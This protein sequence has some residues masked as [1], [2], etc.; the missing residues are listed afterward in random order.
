MPT[1]ADYPD[2]RAYNEA[3]A[4]EFRANGAVT[5]DFAGRNL[6]LLTTTGAKS[7]RAHVTPLGYTLIGERILI[8]AGAGGQANNPDWYHNLV[9]DPEVTVELPGDTFKARAVVTEGEERQRLGEERIKTNANFRR[10][11]ERTSRQ[12]PL[13]WLDR[14]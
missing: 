8:S 14:L 5:G 10:N 6:L 2:G 4:T 1:R 12:I 13:I 3:V 7:G 11:Q 9:A